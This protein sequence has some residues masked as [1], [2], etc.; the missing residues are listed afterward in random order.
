MGGCSWGR[1]GLGN[2]SSTLGSVA[3]PH[4]A[5]LCRA[6]TSLPVWRRYCVIDN[7][8]VHT[9]EEFAECLPRWKKQGLIIKYL[10][11]Y[12]PELNL[13]EILWRNIKYTWLPFSAYQG[14]NA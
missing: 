13:I 10:S 3:L 14:L 5:V 12:S 11:T 9:S 4:F 2:P 8:S 6:P 1:V 7:A